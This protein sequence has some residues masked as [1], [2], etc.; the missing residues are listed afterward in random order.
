[1]KKLDIVPIKVRFTANSPFKIT[2]LLIQLLV[3]VLIMIGG[4]A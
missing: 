4:G 2:A 1:M 3:I